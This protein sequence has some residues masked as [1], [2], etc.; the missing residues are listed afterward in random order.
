MHWQLLPR[1]EHSPWPGE[2]LSAVSCGQVAP[3]QDGEVT[4]GKCPSCQPHQ[5]GAALQLPHGT[6][7]TTT[8]ALAHSSKGHQAVG[9]NH[10]HEGADATFEVALSL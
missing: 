9:A 1:Q 6:D 3:K 8:L 7:G 2:A 10:R 5:A 4:P